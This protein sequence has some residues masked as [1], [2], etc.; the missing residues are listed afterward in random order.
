MGRGRA[1]YIAKSG[2]PGPVVLD[3]AKNAQVE[4]SEYAPAKLDY[5][6]SYQSVP[7]MDEEAVRQAAE[8]INSAERPLVLVGQGVEL[9]ERNK[10][11]VPLSKKLECLPVVPC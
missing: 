4:K 3:F 5:I 8:L 6:R 10:N 11:C 7:E 9:G 2:R 1:F